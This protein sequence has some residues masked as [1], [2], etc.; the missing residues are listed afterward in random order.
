MN[1]IYQGRPVETAAATVPAF[2][3]EQKV[4]AGSVLLE[5]NCEIYGGQAA[6]ET[7]ALKDGDVLN[8]FRIV[9]GG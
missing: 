7:P 1:I 3:A 8:V 6:D 9:A 2:L 4:E 5:L